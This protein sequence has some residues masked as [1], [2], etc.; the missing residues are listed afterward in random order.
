MKQNLFKF[1]ALSFV[2][3]AVSLSCSKNEEPAPPTIVTID[4]T[5]AI[6]AWGNVMQ[7]NDPEEYTWPDL[8][9]NYWFYPMDV[10]GN[11]NVGL[12]IKGQYPTTNARF[13][14]ITMYNDQTMQRIASAEDF[15]IVPNDGS[16]N[17]FNKSNV[18]GSNYFEIN[19][20]PEGSAI[21]GLK[22][23]MTFPSNLQKLSLLLRIYFNSIDHDGGF[24]G[25]DVPQLTFFD[26][27]TGNDIKVAERTD[28]FYYTFFGAMVKSIPVLKKQNAMV[29]TL[30]PNTAYSNGPTG[31][32]SAANRLT[33]GNG[34]FF[35]FIPP[36][37]PTLNNLESNR[38]ADVRY[39]S[40]CVGDTLTYTPHTITDRM[41]VMDGEYVNFMIVAKN[42]PNITNIT[43]KAQTLKINLI[44]WDIEK[45]GEP[46]MVFYRQMY[47]RNGFEHSVQKIT[48][49][50]PLNDKGMPDISLQPMPRNA[51]VAHK[52]LGQNGP[53]GIV[54]PAAM[55][56]Q[57]T[58]AT[59]TIRMGEEA[60]MPGEGQ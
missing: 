14:N 29:F 31:Y 47:I 43:A 39:W 6:A 32:V 19:M 58:F 48:P 55:I 1:I 60:N 42:D 23:V 49:Y 8:S 44:V 37:S 50:P 4:T 11:P 52:V 34:L 46:M 18:T 40:I 20:V 9:E 3:G 51:N 45:H 25:V 21:K 53:Y 27:T 36:V 17:P 7:G 2:I 26:L 15:N 35:R 33:T 22:N 56:L 10:A 28:S 24:G 57:P 38:T 12:R 59:T 16:E 30:A 54:A 13:F 41:I 5:A